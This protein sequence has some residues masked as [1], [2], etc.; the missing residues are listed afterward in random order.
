M[1]SL[2]LMTSRRRALQFLG[3]GSSAFL[4]AAC[5]AAA[6]PVSQAPTAAPAAPAATTPP[7]AAPT[8]AA[9][10]AP[11]KPTVV[12][13]PAPTAASASGTPKMGGTL[14]TIQAGDLSSID[15]H[16]YTTGN[17]LSAWIVYETLTQYDDN[18]KPQ[19]CARRK[20]GPER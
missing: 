4:L 18:L 11:P 16:Y 14:R 7:A 3:A 17:G 9:A 15:G 19:P 2:P 8:T 6:T 20:L 10:A 13:A 5:G 1:S 12:S